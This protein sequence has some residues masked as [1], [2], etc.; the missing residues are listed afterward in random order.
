MINL[1]FLFQSASKNNESSSVF[2][3]VLIVIGFLII[4]GIG[5]F[6]FVEG[7]Y[8]DFIAKKPLFRHLYLF[9]KDLNTNQ[10]RILENDFS[11]Y[12]RLDVK[13][14]KYFRHRVYTFI[15]HVDF[16]GKENLKID[17]EKKTLVA[18]T[19]IM[20]TFGYRDYAI[21]LVDKILIYPTVFYSKLDKNYHKGH[22]NPGYRA[23]ILSWE[24]F[25]HGHKIQDDNLN[26]G[27]HEFV[28]A[29]HLSYL[30]SKRNNDIS[31]HIF[32]SS[33][34][35]LHAYI[36]SKA[37]LKLHMENS[38]Y[39]RSY[40][41]KNDFEFTA[42]IIENFIETPNEFKIH[43]PNVYKHVKQMLNFNFIGY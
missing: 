12:K 29:L 16:I 22:F 37:N 43:F 36:Q 14:Q 27:I 42:V 31:A 30:H 25:V 5:L 4:A 18:A 9:P 17:D 10:K 32:T 11:F 33:L 7:F 19:A 28:H 40:A 2:F 1:L 41:F 8:V 13:Q 35:A 3:V 39:F 24:D 26:L 38:T 20:L 21:N 6:K 34:D 15:S 23:I